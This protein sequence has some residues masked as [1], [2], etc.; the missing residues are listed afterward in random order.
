MDNQIYLIAQLPPTRFDEP[1]EMSV[2][3]FLREAEK[4]LSESEWQLLQQ[5][6][7]GGIGT[8]VGPPSTLEDLV[9]FERRLRT[10]VGHWRQAQRE[11]REYQPLGFESHLLAEGTPMEV[12][13]RLMK[14]RWDFIDDLE[15]EHHFDVERVILHLCKLVIQ[16][17]LHG[18]DAEAGRSI[19]QTITEVEVMS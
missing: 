16:Q 7:T 5:I 8:A 15:S 1:P 11:N 19:F 12:E 10:E 4:W 18:F 6:A 9:L 3:G 14:L 2:D 17:R 13:E